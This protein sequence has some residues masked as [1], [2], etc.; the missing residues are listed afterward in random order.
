MTITTIAI[1]DLRRPS[2]NVRHHPRKQIEELKRSVVMFGQTRALICDE[3]HTVL[4]GN[5]LLTALEELG[6]TEAECYII[7]GLSEAGKK[8]LMLADNRVY[9]LGLTD[10]N[11]FDVI[12]RELDGD[13][14][15]PGWDEALLKT[16][17]A[18]TAEADK[19]IGGYG[20]YEP[21]EVQS[22]NAKS[23]EDKSPTDV[24]GEPYKPVA[25]PHISSYEPPKDI[26][27][28]TPD[29]QPQRYIVCP[30]CGEKICL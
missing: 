9:D 14:D 3:N 7:A 24:V 28:N 6:Y 15:I 18:T 2:R 26:R 16:L 17:T 27:A 10:M 4:A 25:T 1:A 19:L 12:L 5:G 21:E 13:I 30:K 23:R 20:A 11:A 8:K 29:H 22:L